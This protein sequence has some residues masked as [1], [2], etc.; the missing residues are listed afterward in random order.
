MTIA[1]VIQIVMLRD[2]F[3]GGKAR[4]SRSFSLANLHV[5]AH[6]L[7]VNTRPM[8]KQVMA[9]RD[10][11]AAYMRARR[12]RPKVEKAAIEQRGGAP[13]FTTHSNG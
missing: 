6:R 13:V 2:G 5:N 1:L 4:K 11:M 12:A 7:R 3:F 8:E 10:D 9:A